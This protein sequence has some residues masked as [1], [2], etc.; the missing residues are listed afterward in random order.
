VS[1]HRV[2]DWD[3]NVTFTQDV[4]ECNLE[5]L[6]RNHLCSLV[7][8]DVA[9]PRTAHLSR[10][11]VGSGARIGDGAII[12][13]SVVFPGA[14]VTPGSSLRRVIVTPQGTLQFGQGGQRRGNELP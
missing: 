8:P 7:A 1:I 12:E 9:I 3:M 11:V 14:A 4:L 2:V 6:S 5:Y 13:E 10:C